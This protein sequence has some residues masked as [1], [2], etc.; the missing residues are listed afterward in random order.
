MRILFILLGA[1]ILWPFGCEAQT[2][3]CP[4]IYIEN[5]KAEQELQECK[6]DLTDQLD[7]NDALLAE[8]KTLEQSI[9]TK[10]GQITSLN[11]TI[12]IKDEEITTLNN[13]VAQKDEQIAGNISQIS[14]LD[15]Q[16][17]SLKLDLEECVNKPGTAP[18]CEFITIG[19]I[20]YKVSDITK[21][22]PM[23]T[24]DT[25]DIAFCQDTTGLRDYIHEGSI[26]QYPHF[27]N[28]ASKT[29]GL[30]KVWFETPLDS[31]IKV[32]DYW[33]VRRIRSHEHAKTEL[34]F[35]SSYS[36]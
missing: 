30:V 22:L 13:T 10:D 33:K 8:N 35:I 18:D 27:I 4:P 3:D 6:D 26:T 12:S 28:V 1:L 20:E 21:I 29:R 7:K 25:I 9:T 5:P 11:L 36:D 34:T 24:V 2:P 32:Q 23:Q 14:D 17:N 31:A 16:V 15:D 19:G